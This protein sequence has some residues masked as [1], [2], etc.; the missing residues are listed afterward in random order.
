M[1]LLIRTLTA[2]IVLLLT[3]TLGEAC[4]EVSSLDTPTGEFKAQGTPTPVTDDYGL[5]LNAPVQTPV[6]IPNQSSQLVAPAK[7][8]TMLR[9]NIHRRSA[10]RLSANIYTSI[11]AT[12]RLIME[13]MSAPMR[14]PRAVHF[15]VLELCRLLC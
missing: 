10:N 6:L 13:Q 11:A 2:T 1:R 3:L 7:Y 5:V 4:R 12:G 9:A 8:R 14:S 15:Y